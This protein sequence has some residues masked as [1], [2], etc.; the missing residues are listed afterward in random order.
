[1]VPLFKGSTRAALKQVTAFGQLN[2][3]SKYHLHCSVDLPYQSSATYYYVCG[4]SLL[5]GSHP[6]DPE[7]K[8]R[9]CGLLMNAPKSLSQFLFVKA[10]VLGALFLAS[11]I[12]KLPARKL[13]VSLLLNYTTEPCRF[14]FSP[15]LS[16]SWWMRVDLQPS[17]WVPFLFGASSNER[18]LL[19]T[20]ETVVQPEFP[21]FL[22]FSGTNFTSW[23]CKSL[24]RSGKNWPKQLYVLF[25]VH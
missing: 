24:C 23:I 3:R 6:M 9:R 8:I 18:L 7:N 5:A 20:E 2:S 25:A 4:C 19:R 21:C 13:A 12:W 1:M 10:W 15:L 17:D 11:F 16:C 22:A 14:N